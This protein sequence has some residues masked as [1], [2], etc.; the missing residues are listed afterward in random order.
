M[1]KK[2]N[3]YNKLLAPVFPKGTMIFTQYYNECETWVS[4]GKKFK[5]IKRE[6]SNRG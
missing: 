4:D 2:K 1:S 5:Q 3:I 6:L